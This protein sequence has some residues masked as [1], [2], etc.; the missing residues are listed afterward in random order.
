MT[1]ANWDLVS[2][3][4]SLSLS[5]SNSYCDDDYTQRDD[6]LCWTGD[7]VGDY[8]QLLVNTNIPQRYNPEV[9]WDSET[10]PNQLNVLVDKLIKIR[11]SIGS[12]V[13]EEREGDRER[14]R[15]LVL[16]FHSLVTGDK[17]ANA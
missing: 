7:R 12:V 5:H 15:A 13:S 11:H 2:L 3:F 17:C 4:L 8:T 1:K 9:P 14:E 6:R 16:I 10:R